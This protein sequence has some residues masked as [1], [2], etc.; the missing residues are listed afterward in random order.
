MTPKSNMLFPISTAIKNW[1]KARENYDADLLATEQRAKDARVSMLRE[2]QLKRDMAMT[3]QFVDEGD[4]D[5]FNDR[6]NQLVERG[7]NI[8]E[9]TKHEKK[10]NVIGEL[11]DAYT[12]VYTSYTAKA[13]KK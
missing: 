12:R 13:T 11:G 10:A 1:M 6:I 7:Y 5:N 9:I 4:I 3:I 8:S 2:A